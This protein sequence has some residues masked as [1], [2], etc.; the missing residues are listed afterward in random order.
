MAKTTSTLEVEILSSLAII[1]S[2]ER[3]YSLAVE[4][5]E[6]A[7]AKCKKLPQF[8][9]QLYIRINYNFSRTSVFMDN[10]NLAYN[11]VNDAIITSYRIHS[12]YLLGESHFQRGYCSYLLGQKAKAIQDVADSLWIFSKTENQAMHDIASQY[13]KKMK[14]GKRL[15]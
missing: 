13:Y 3:N 10:L 5:Y 9:A 14:R 7:L 11:L 6:L 4:K 12:L 8:N 1:E 15:A 2:E